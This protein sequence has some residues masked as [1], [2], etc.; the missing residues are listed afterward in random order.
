M[1]WEGISVIPSLPAHSQPSLSSPSNALETQAVQWVAHLNHPEAG[2]KM[3]G[4]G[5]LGM[6][7]TRAFDWCVWAKIPQW[8]EQEG[9]NLPLF[10]HSL[11]HWDLFHFCP[12]YSCPQTH[13][14]LLAS[15]YPDSS[16]FTKLK[17]KCKQKESKL[18]ASNLNKKCNEVTICKQAGCRA[19]RNWERII[20]KETKRGKPAKAPSRSRTCTTPG[21]SQLTGGI[22]CSL[23]PTTQLKTDWWFSLFT[24]RNQ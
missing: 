12:H 14:F 20:R 6:P 1:Q 18:T 7:S 24:C 23:L 5:L 11:S 3:V 2:A 10:C 17:M 21:T 16:Q 19:S 8:C 13:Y 15:I 22:W 4:D 9:Q